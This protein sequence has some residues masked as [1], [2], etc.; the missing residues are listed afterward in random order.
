MKEYS[1]VF[2][3]K[4]IVWKTQKNWAITCR[5]LVLRLQDGT[6]H[7]AEFHFGK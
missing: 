3:L 1:V 2:S 5:T 7:A 6:T 4:F